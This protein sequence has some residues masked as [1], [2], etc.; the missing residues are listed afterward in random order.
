MNLIRN[1]IKKLNR[2]LLIDTALIF[3][4][5]VMIVIYKASKI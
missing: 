3:L 5:T 4:I 2:S 1:S